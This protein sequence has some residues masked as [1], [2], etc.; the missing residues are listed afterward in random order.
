M[1][2]DAML[3]QINGDAAT[4]MIVIAI[5]AFVWWIQKSIDPRSPR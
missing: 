5:M 4:I 3:T 1:T 2:K